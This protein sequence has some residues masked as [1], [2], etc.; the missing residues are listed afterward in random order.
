M[1]GYYAGKI[2]VIC[3]DD[4]MCFP[5]HPTTLEPLACGTY[6]PYALAD[7]DPEPVKTMGF[8]EWAREHDKIREES[9][10]KERAEMTKY[11]LE[12]K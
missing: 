11:W 1:N 8:N 3:H 9:M 5:A 6:D 4:L 2:K 10:R 7:P 12:A